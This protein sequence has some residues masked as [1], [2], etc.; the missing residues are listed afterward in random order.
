M[1]IAFLI[2]VKINKL[3]LNS[4]I[5]NL[6]NSFFINK[7]EKYNYNFYLGFNYNDKC[8]EN[9]KIFNKFNSNNFSVNIKEFN[10]NIRTG[11]L[12]KMWNELFHVSYK[13]NDY[14][15]QLG[16]DILMDN[17]D[18]LDQYINVLESM[19][20]LGVTGYLTKNGNNEILTQSFVS[21]KHYEIFGYYFPES[22]INW[23]CDNWISDVYKKFNLY[24][25]L[26][27]K[28]T[29]SSDTER[30]KIT[31]NEENYR[32]DLKE[33]IRILRTYIAN[34]K[35]SKIK[36]WFKKLFKIKD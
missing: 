29:N 28:I 11:H 36:S 1:N 6:L 9:K 14:F 24:K 34:K 15:Y 2:P 23:C 31:Y 26:D 10:S 13:D 7:V 32:I 19:D 3:D 20:N 30:Y 21:K 5:Y 12:T 33:G 4:K 16:D 17:Y 8:L 25:P 35:M 27:K 18:F 22:I